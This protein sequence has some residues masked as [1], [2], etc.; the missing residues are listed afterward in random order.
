MDE[1]GGRREQ[2]PADGFTPRPVQPGRDVVV[3]VA[4][5]EMA[6]MAATELGGRVAQRLRHPADRCDLAPADLHCAVSLSLHPPQDGIR[7]G[8]AQ[9]RKRVRTGGGHES[10][11]IHHA[12]PAQL[13]TRSK[14]TPIPLST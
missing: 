3:Q 9:R 5:G 8:Q 10:P 4:D 6:G 11:A 2:L 13:D 1:L 12:P 7:V 14:V